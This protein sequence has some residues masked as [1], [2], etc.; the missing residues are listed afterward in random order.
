MEMNK[1]F[2]IIFLLILPYI[3]LEANQDECSRVAKCSEDG[4][5]V[6]FPFRLRGHHPNHCGYPGFDLSCTTG[7]ETMV[8]LPFSGKFIVQ[9]IDYENQFL[10]VSDPDS[11][12][13]RRLLQHLNFSKSPFQLYQGYLYRKHSNLQNPTILRR[14]FLSARLHMDIKIPLSGK[15]LVAL[16]SQDMKYMLFTTTTSTSTSTSTPKSLS[17]KTYLLAPSL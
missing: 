3:R 10:D 8:E 4:P 7:N 12:I 6:R 13:P 15:R 9:T 17:F 16:E 14:A 1:N 5:A 11:C 2:M